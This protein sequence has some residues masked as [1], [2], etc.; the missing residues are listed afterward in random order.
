MTVTALELD[1]LSLPTRSE[2]FDIANDEDSSGENHVLADAETSTPNSPSSDVTETDEEFESEE[3][4]VNV[5]TTVAQQ[6]EM[7]FGIN[8]TEVSEDNDNN[9]SNSNDETNVKLS[10]ADRATLGV[11]KL[12]H[13]AGV[14]LEYYNILFAFLR[15]HSSK[16]KV[17]ITK[18]PKRDTFLKSLRA[19][20]FLAD[21]YYLS[22]WQFAIPTLQYTSSNS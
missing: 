5:S 17:D 10:P 13:D 19:R 22:S 16:H 14:S 15:K 9:D 18:L 12:C 7:H 4:A 3:A 1:A 11:L 6:V 21:A 2:G 8:N 20:I